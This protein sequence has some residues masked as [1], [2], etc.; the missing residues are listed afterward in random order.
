SGIDGSAAL[1][2][3][4]APLATKNVAGDGTVEFD[5]VVVPFGT[6]ALSVAYLGDGSGNFAFSESAAHPFLVEEAA[7]E[8]RLSVSSH[9]VSASETV[10]FVVTVRNISEANLADPRS[11]FQ[12][13]IDGDVFYAEVSSNDGDP[14]QADGTAQFEVEL[15]NLPIGSHTV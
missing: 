7:T 13:L 9:H 6:T 5:D 12:I 11:G 2:A 4:G 3:D 8:T 14:V 10:N 1:L 15:S